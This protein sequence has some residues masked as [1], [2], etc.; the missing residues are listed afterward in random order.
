LFVI[1]RVTTVKVPFT[2]CYLTRALG[3]D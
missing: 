2:P 3:R 1:N